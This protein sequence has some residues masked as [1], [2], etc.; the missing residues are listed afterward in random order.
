MSIVSAQITSES[1]THAEEIIGFAVSVN[2][3]T[4]PPTTS[5]Q[6]YVQ[7]LVDALHDVVAGSTATITSPP[8]SRV[9]VIEI[10]TTKMNATMRGDLDKMFNACLNSIA[11]AEKANPNV[12]LKV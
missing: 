9:K 7:I 12:I 8:G 6:G 4:T 3:N 11:V 10:D 2:T 1:L 5:I